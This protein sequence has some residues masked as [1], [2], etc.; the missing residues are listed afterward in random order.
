[1]IHIHIRKC[2]CAKETIKK[3]LSKK[4]SSFSIEKKTK[5][6]TFNFFFW[7]PYKGLLIKRHHSDD[8]D[9][10]SNIMIF[11]LLLLT[12]KSTKWPLLFQNFATVDDWWTKTDAPI[13]FFCFVLMIKFIIHHIFQSKWI[14]LWMMRL[15]IDFFFVSNNLFHCCVCECVCIYYPVARIDHLFCF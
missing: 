15:I 3:K 8:D 11:L 2:Q 13:V 1:M 5:F 10:Q 6:L 12:F 14:N 7:Q 4:I 9:G